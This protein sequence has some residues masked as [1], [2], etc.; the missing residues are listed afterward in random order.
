MM[1]QAVLSLC[2]DHELPSRI[3]SKATLKQPQ[4]VLFVSH[5]VTLA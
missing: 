4:P 1:K 3:T 5:P 2:N